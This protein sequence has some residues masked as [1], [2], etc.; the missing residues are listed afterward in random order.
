MNK[1]EKPKEGWTLEQWEEFTFLTQVEKTKWIFRPD[2]DIFSKDLHK[3]W[4][5]S[6]IEE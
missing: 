4:L 5:Q 1:N 2:V 6:R 3:Q